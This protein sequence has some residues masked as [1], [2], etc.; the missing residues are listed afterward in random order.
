MISSLREKF[1]SYALFFYNELSPEV[2]GLVWRPE[3]VETTSFSAM[4]A[5]YARPLDDDEKTW[6]NDSLV[7]RNATDLLREMSEY[8]QHV[9]TSVKIIDE[10][11]LAPSSKRQKV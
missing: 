7:I 4:T 6:K 1:G 2:I 8:Y 3:T 11:C 9:I 5:E 10:S